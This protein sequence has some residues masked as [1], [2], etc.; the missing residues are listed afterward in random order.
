[1]YHPHFEN[2]LGLATLDTDDVDLAE[3]NAL[4]LYGVIYNAL[5]C[6]RGLEKW[7]VGPCSKPCEGDRYIHDFYVDLMMVEKYRD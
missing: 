1:M 5:R 4:N 3:M 2:G 7:P 6:I